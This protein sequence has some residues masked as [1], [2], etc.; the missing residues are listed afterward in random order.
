MGARSHALEHKNQDHDKNGEQT[1]LLF[2]SRWIFIFI[3]FYLFFF[4]W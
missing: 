2:N 3:S 4:M 1:Q